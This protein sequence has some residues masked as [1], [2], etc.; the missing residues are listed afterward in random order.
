MIHVV[1]RLREFGHGR[2]KHFRFII[3]LLGGLPAQRHHVTNAGKR[4]RE[5]LLTD[6]IRETIRGIFTLQLNASQ[7]VAERF[8]LWLQRTCGVAR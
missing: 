2:I 4:G 5:S 3:L 8:E 1:L 6:L 7:G